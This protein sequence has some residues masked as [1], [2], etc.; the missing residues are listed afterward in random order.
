MVLPSTSNSETR[1]DLASNGTNTTDF[2]GKAAFGPLPEQPA[3]SHAVEAIPATASNSSLPNRQ[4]EKL[5]S[6]EDSISIKVTPAATIVSPFPITS[7]ASI[8]ENEMDQEPIPYRS[9]NNNTNNASEIASHP[10][11]ASAIQFG[12]SS[13]NHLFSHTPSS[14]L[15]RSSS[16]LFSHSPQP[17]PWRK[18]LWLKQPYP[19]NY[20]DSSF[21]SQLKQ[22]SHVQPYSFWILSAD[23]SPVLAHL[24]SV[25]LFGIVFCGIYSRG[26][27]PT[28]FATA[29][30]ILSIAGYIFLWT[31]EGGCWD[32]F[33]RLKLGN[34]D[35]NG[36]AGRDD[37]NTDTV[38]KKLAAPTTTDFSFS[39]AT[40]K[41]AMLIVFTILALSPV[42]KSLTQSTSSDS[43][44]ALAC[45]LTLA[46]VLCQDYKGANPPSVRHANN[47][48]NNNNNADNDDNGN[49]PDFV[50]EE[51]RSSSLAT[52]L[53]MAAAIVLASRL[54][55]TIAVFS[56][57][58]FSI[59]LFG[60]FPAFIKRIR[61]PIPTMIPKPTEPA[62]FVG[63]SGTAKAGPNGGTSKPPPTFSV[64][65]SRYS[66]TYW[67]L[68]TFLVIA[69]DI[70][71][72][73]ISGPSVIVSNKAQG[74]HHHED[75]D[76][77]DIVF[78][79]LV[80]LAWF[81]IQ[82]MVLLVLPF[83]LL[84]LQKYKNEIQGP[85]DPAKPKLIKRN[86]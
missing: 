12:R 86:M 83:W 66:K 73:Y 42:L 29:S 2:G 70:G 55:T 33:N 45:W 65:L 61:Y 19:D 81:L 80:L 9:T 5:D 32:V 79:L 47:N 68:L 1:N 13:T 27:N 38:L 78:R 72:W 23:F 62:S 43:I 51:F 24:C 63:S 64:A 41:S 25:A 34:D 11:F 49:G 59:E 74:Q 28:A 6:D 58:L 8:I 44:W 21:L 76:G 75:Q 36:M 14:H 37:S 18:L 67:I 22:N 46:N 56:F 31:W 17:P 39:L 35:G 7:S 57:I 16:P 4:P 26:W 20:V 82:A 40:I 48:N 50:T 84:S 69:S 77:S 53:A 85:W 52:N 15:S 3:L 60:V 30:V 10:S 71:L 54:D